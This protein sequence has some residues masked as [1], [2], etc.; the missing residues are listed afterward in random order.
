[1]S[2]DH[3]STLLRRKGSQ[4]STVPLSQLIVRYQLEKTFFTQE[5][6]WF[7]E[8]KIGF[9]CIVLCVVASLAWEAPHPL[10]LRLMHSKH[11]TLPWAY[12]KL[13]H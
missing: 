8:F 6:F 11:H 5:Q 9:N 4:C 1:M 3:L 10:S 12:K 13:L 2:I 7:E